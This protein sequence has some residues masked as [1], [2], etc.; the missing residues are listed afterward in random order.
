[1]SIS[2]DNY[3][4]S[5]ADL[6]KTTNTGGASKLEESLANKDFKGASDEEIMEVCKEFEA[7]FIEQL[8]KGMEVMIP[9]NEDKKSSASK[10]VDYFKDTMIQEIAKD[11]ADTQGLGIAQMLFESMK[12][13][14][15]I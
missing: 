4:G 5:L 2:V 7:Y 15:G 13:D 9:K 10:T 1:M 11:T 6:Y 8:F 3:A 12:R 14:Y